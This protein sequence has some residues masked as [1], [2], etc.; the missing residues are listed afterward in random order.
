MFLFEK[1]SYRLMASRYSSKRQYANELDCPFIYCENKIS[2]E[3]ITVPFSHDRRGRETETDRQTNRQTQTDRHRQ[4]G[5][6]YRNSLS[7][8]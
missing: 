8:K 5:Y 4:I 3:E 2:R 7:T 6:L 1:Y